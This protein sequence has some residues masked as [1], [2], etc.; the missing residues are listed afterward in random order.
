MMFPFWQLAVC[1]LTNKKPRRQENA[2]AFVC[3]EM[4]VRTYGYFLEAVHTR[5]DLN[6][7]PINYYIHNAI[8]NE[9]AAETVWLLLTPHC[10]KQNPNRSLV[11]EYHSCGLKAKNLIYIY[12]MHCIQS[13]SVIASKLESKLNSKMGKLRNGWKNNLKIN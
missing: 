2:R 11:Y 4:T 5:V 10:Q 12:L 8:N 3:V 7:T 9:N 13:E 6:W 1:P